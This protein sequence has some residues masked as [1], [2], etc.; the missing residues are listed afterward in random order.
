MLLLQLCAYFELHKDEQCENELQ[1]I[2]ENRKLV[3]LLVFH[4]FIA[5]FYLRREKFDKV[6]CN[7][8]RF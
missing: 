3:E 5:L 8:Y 6:N 7:I 4:T 1:G 2:R